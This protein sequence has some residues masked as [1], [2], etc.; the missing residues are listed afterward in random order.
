M[1]LINAQVKIE[2]VIQMSVKMSKIIAA[3][4]AVDMVALSLKRSLGSPSLEVSRTVNLRFFKQILVLLHFGCLLS[5]RF[6]RKS[7]VWMQLLL[8]LAQVF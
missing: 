2:I 3:S 5:F 6:H 7:F 4:D 8:I 1:E